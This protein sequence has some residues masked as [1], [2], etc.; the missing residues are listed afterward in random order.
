MKAGIYE[1]SDFA[2]SLF[3]F[4][5]HFQIPDVENLQVPVGINWFRRE[6]SDFADGW[7]AR[8]L[9]SKRRDCTQKKT[10]Q[11]RSE[12]LAIWTYSYA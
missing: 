10:M 11:G 2:L 7:F 5:V 8:V 9:T 3:S 12:L 4:A 1:I 6:N